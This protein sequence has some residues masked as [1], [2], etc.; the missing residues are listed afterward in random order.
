LSLASRR[1]DLI[2]TLDSRPS[3]ISACT[4]LFCALP[5]GVGI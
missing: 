5:S 1:I 4:A 3:S 2:A